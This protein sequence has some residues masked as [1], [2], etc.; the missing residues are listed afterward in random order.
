MAF[1]QV[2]SITE[3]SFSSAATSH[4]ANYPAT[5]NAGELL[6]IFASFNGAVTVSATG[7]T[8]MW[9]AQASSFV[10]GAAY[11]KAAAGSEGGGTIDVVTSV[12][13]TG[14]V[15]IYRITNFVD[16]PDASDADAAAVGTFNSGTQ[17]ASTT[18]TAGWGTEDNLF[19]TVAATGDDDA[20]VSTYPT[21]YG[22]GVNTLSEGGV[23][24]S[25]AVG[26]ARRELAASSD[27]AGDFTLDSTEAWVLCAVVVRPGGSPLAALI[28]A[29]VI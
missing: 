10:T 20:A 22:N 27:N 12:A 16:R 13:A 5:V 1:P 21:N 24:T 19:I 17:Q 15:K 18:V 9:D 3:T 28:A 14:A 29:G 25:A 7:Y 4:A 23:D 11:K 8:E 26:S 2:A 6:L